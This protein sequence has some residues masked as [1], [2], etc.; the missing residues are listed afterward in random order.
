MTLKEFALDFLIKNPHVKSIIY[1]T[2][3]Q[4]HLKEIYT[5]FQELGV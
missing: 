2:S 4:E 3:Q 5:L 1:G